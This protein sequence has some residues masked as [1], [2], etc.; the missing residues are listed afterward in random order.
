MNFL[1]QNIRYLRKV[2]QMTQQQLADSLDIKRAL[3]GSYEEGRATPK[4]LI[5]QRLSA[6]FGFSIDDLLGNDLELGMP[7]K[8]GPESVLQILPIVVDSKNEEL[9]PIVPVKALAGYLNGY[10]D[11][12]FVESLPRFFMPIPELSRERTYRVFQI[13]G[14]SMLPVAPGAYVFCEFLADLESVKD[15]QTYVLVTKTE[16]LVYKR[17]FHHEENRFL[18]KSDNPEYEPYFIEAADLLE[19][20]RAKGILTFDLPLPDVGGVAHISSVLKEVKDEIRKLRN[21]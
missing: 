4:V 19:I 8:K 1:A 7:N 10:S 3:V 16:G 2:N 14:D 6:L 15:G 18:L 20:W 9:I 13:K 12:E 17:V 11:P 21:L 5:L